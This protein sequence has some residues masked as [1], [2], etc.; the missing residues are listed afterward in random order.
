MAGV[1][2]GV[3]ILCLTDSAAASA[4]RLRSPV[5]TVLL[6][7]AATRCAWPA[8]ACYRCTR[9][10]SATTDEVFTPDGLRSR[11]AHIIRLHPAWQQPSARIRTCCTIA[12]DR[13]II[14]IVALFSPPGTRPRPLHR[15]ATLYSSPSSP[16]SG[17]LF[18]GR[19]SP[20]WPTF[21]RAPSLGEEGVQTC[22]LR[23]LV[24]E[25]AAAVT[26]ADPEVARLKSSAD[27][28]QRSSR[29]SGS[30]EPAR[31]S[32]DVETPWSASAQRRRWAEA[33][34]PEPYS[35]NERAQIWNC[36]RY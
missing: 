5:L 17:V 23:D 27:L 15:T 12:A 18:V 9:G 36:S 16:P 28:V 1:V 33:F 26:E 29:P 8:G 10:R 6:L 20:T 25:G 13:P 32:D 22:T 3:D 14:A 21:R 2:V 34:R 19:T 7:P 24:A 4:V 31:Q 30:R 11:R 35:D